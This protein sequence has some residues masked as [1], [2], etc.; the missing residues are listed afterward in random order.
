VGHLLGLS[1]LGINEAQGRWRAEL[2][3]ADGSAV[4]AYE[5]WIRAQGGD[6][7]EEA[8]PKAPIVREVVSPGSGWVRRLGAIQVGIAALHLGAGRTTKEDD[9]DHGVGVL[10]LKK[11]GDDV[12][13]GEP[14]AEVHARD[15]ATAEEA[16]QEVLA[17]YELGDE[18]GRAHGIVLDVVG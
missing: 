15:E 8:L 12:T 10:C 13:A 1:D 17:A 2:A 6:P 7:D 14:L 4:E 16:A 18:P 9:I 5:R 11:R 3:I